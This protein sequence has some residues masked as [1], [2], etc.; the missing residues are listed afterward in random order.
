MRAQTKLTQ[1]NTSYDNSLLIDT[2]PKKFNF[3][4]SQIT[5]SMRCLS[6]CIVDFTKNYILEIDSI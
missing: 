5:T 1:T 6:T 3:E 4:S 2:I